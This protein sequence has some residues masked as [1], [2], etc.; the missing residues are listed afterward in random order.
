MEILNQLG[1]LFVFFKSG[2]I[3]GIL[4]SV[5][6]ILLIVVGIERFIW[7]FL[8]K[9]YK[10]SNLLEGM[11]PFVV[12]RNYSEALQVA[13]RNNRAPQME[14]VKVALLSVENGREAMKSAQ[15]SEL[16][17]I[18]EKCEERLP[19]I[20]LIANVATLLGLLG[21][22]T[23]L[24]KTF[25]G[26]AAMDA[27]AKAS[28][29]GSGISEAMNSTAVGLS[30]GITAMIIHSVYSTRAERIISSCQDAGLKILSWVEQAERKDGDATT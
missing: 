26:L 25:E 4:I 14:V 18:I 20:S 11:R 15:G 8:L 13:S 10:V 19:L 22:I 23:G 6:A 29:L 30:V 17:K 1:D 9:S 12:Q 7:L 2:G 5:S 21:T 3:A 28:A 24:I 16:V 27:S